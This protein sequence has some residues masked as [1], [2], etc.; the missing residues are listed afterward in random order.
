MCA[1]KDA[2]TGQCFSNL[3]NLCLQLV[4]MT[5]VTTFL[6]TLDNLNPSIYHSTRGRSFHND[7]R[8]E[9]GAAKYLNIEL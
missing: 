8:I 4:F 9:R 1:N 2:R 7:A 3:V 5:V 6:T